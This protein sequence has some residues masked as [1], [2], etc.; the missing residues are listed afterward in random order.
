MSGTALKTNGNDITMD[1]LIAT[2]REFG[3]KNV[4]LPQ[5]PPNNIA[6]FLPTG[7]LLDNTGATDVSALIKTAHD[8]A[9]AAG[10]RTMWFPPGTYYAPTLSAVAD[11]IF[12]GP[13]VLTGAYRKWIFP[14]ATRPSE[15]LYGDVRTSHRRR[16]DQAVAAATPSQPAIIVLMGSFLRDEVVAVQYR[17]YP[18][19]RPMNARGGVRGLRSGVQQRQQR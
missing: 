15:L 12:V 4:T 16:F 11:V 7:T 14:E 3:G 5:V 6:A 18:H 17:V 8:V 13:G 19:Y 9:Q 2:I 1:R 10:Y